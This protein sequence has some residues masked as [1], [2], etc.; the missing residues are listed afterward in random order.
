MPGG[1]KRDHL[2]DMVLHYST[3]DSHV[4]SVKT[5]MSVKMMFVERAATKQLIKDQEKETS[6]RPGRTG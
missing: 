4:S 2:V 1:Q 6:S 3:K 5:M